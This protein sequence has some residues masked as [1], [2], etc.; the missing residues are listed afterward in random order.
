MNENIRN[1]R[2]NIYRNVEK[3]KTETEKIRE[4]F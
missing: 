4:E 1:I 2:N 3:K